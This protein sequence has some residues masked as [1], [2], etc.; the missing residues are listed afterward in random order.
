MRIPRRPGSYAV[1]PLVA[2]V[3]SA[4]FATAAS[5]ST[6]EETTFSISHTAPKPQRPLNVRAL[7]GGVLA[8]FDVHGE[9][10]RVWTTNRQAIEQ[11]FALA[12]RESTA[13][14][15][16]GRLR[17]GPGRAA[18]N[19]PWSWHLDPEHFGLADFT[20]EL[21]DARPSYVEENLFYFLVTVG[22]YCP[23]GAVLVDLRDFR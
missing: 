1:L 14:I 3:A 9:T 4:V 20:I 22:S 21:C 8:T 11:L 6:R 19:A 17:A 7:R 10:F 13:T 18:H 16:I 2:L 12:R 15:P 5:S 23:W